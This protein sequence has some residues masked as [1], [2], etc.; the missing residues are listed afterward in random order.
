MAIFGGIM[1][2]ILI[3]AFWYLLIPFLLMILVNSIFDFDLALWQAV[4][5]WF[6]AVMIGKLFRGGNNNGN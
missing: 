5:I 1:L 6:F 2:L 4:L 3:I